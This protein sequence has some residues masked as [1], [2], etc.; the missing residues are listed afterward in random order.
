MGAPGELISLPHPDPTRR[1]PVVSQHWCSITKDIGRLTAFLSVFE[2]RGRERLCL[3]RAHT[4]FDRHIPCINAALKRA[5]RYRVAS[6][7][8]NARSEEADKGRV[9]PIT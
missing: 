1:T 6:E 4:R 2:T 7:E 8:I 5:R 9:L 3:T